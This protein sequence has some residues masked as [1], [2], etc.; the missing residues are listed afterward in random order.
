VAGDRA[1]GKARPLLASFYSL[2]RG[3]GKAGRASAPDNAVTTSAESNKLRVTRTWLY[4][5][6]LLYLADVS[7]Y[8]ADVVAALSAVLAWH[9][10]PSLLPRPRV[11][12]KDADRTDSTDF[13]AGPFLMS[14]SVFFFCFFIALFIVFGSVREIKLVIRIF[15]VHVNIVYRIAP[16]MQ[17]LTWLGI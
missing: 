7:T 16:D 14:I 11:K 1:C 8:S 17:L 13:M 9:T 15:W 4:P 12:T 6:R 5:L 3:E 2:G 10:R